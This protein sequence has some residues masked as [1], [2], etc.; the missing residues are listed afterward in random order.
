MVVDGIFLSHPDLAPHWEYLIWLD[1]DVETMIQRAL[2]RDAAWVGSAEAV[3]RRYRRFR[4]PVH[5]HYE[6]L[7]QAPAR[8][9]AVVDNR[10]LEHP[11]LVRLTRP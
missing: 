3:E 9:H 4:Q 8:A 2:V 11:R 7:T 6:R 10:D 5:E 1:V